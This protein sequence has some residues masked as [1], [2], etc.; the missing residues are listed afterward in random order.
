MEDTREKT[1]VD[2]IRYLFQKVSDHPCKANSTLEQH[3]WYRSN[4]KSVRAKR[5]AWEE[6]KSLSQQIFNQQ[7][8]WNK[9]LLDSWMARFLKGHLG[10]RRFSF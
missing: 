2:V 1:Y 8:H 3:S 5:R 4:W 6:S 7:L 10:Y 9:H